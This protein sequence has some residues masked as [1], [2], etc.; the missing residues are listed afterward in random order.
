MAGLDSY[1]S[2]LY[3][4]NNSPNDRSDNTNNFTSI[5]S[6]DTTN[7]KFGVASANFSS[8]NWSAPGS[9]DFNFGSGDFTIDFWIRFNNTGT[10]NTMVSTDDWPYNDQAW[11]A[12][13]Q[14]SGVLTFTV[15]RDA[16]DASMNITTTTTP[17]EVAYQWF[18]IAIVR[19][20]ATPYYFVDGVSQS[21]TIGD[22][23]GGDLGLNNNAVL[24]LGGYTY[25]GGGSGRMDELRISKG[26]ARWTSN[27][28]PP[29]SEYSEADIS[30]ILS[31]ESRIVIID[32]S[33]W[34]VEH[35]TVHSAGSYIIPAEGGGGLKTV[36][37]YPTDTDKQMVS[38]NGVSPAA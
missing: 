7:K 9:S 11:W 30:G 16:G 13:R 20:G 34:I 8:G 19:A 21:L 33:T 23:T 22:M 14:A 17:C 1:V 6:Y 3:S 32:E 12:K 10:S 37:A 35:N 5:G 31:E 15:W 36:M 25:V 24:K 27:F 28:T 18:H 29:T 38:Y 26:I 2:A 4:F